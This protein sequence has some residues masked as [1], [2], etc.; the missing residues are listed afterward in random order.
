MTAIG[1][2]RT[3]NEPST[4]RPMTGEHLYVI[5]QT[6]CRQVNLLESMALEDIRNGRGVVF[7]DPHGQSAQTIADS[8]PVSRPG[9]GV[10]RI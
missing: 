10:S 9:C 1:Y 6:G 7:I 2:N 4:F 3:T 8:I 5:G